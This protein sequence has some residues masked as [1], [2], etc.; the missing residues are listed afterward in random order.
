MA[1]RTKKVG[2]TG[3]Y[4]TRYGA[5]LRKLVKRVEVQQRSKYLCPHCGKTA[6]KRKAAGIWSC[7]PCGRVYAGGC[8]QFSTAA[9]ASVQATIQ[10]LKSK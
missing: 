5:T 1:R 6:V 3:R 10:N 8:W 7:K 2:I 4:G 9:A